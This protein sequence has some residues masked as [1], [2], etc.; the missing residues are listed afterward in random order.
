[1]KNASTK[2]CKQTHTQ[3]QTRTIR[4]NLEIVKLMTQAKHNFKYNW[5]LLVINAQTALLL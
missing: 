4:L 2:H 3:T 1:M 5:K